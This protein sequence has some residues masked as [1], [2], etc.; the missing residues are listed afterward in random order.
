MILLMP[1]AHKITFP[2]FLSHPKNI[3]LHCS[4]VHRLLHFPSRASATD[5]IRNSQSSVVVVGLPPEEITSPTIS[6]AWREFL[7]GMETLLFYPWA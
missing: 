7:I 4:T 3:H 6:L 2:T 1:T 5:Q